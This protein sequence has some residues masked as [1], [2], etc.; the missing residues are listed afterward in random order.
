MFV[1]WSADILV[2]SQISFPSQTSSPQNPWA[3]VG[4]IITSPKAAV[5]LLWNVLVGFVF[6]AMGFKSWL[7]EDLAGVNSCD[8]AKNLKLL[9]G[10]CLTVNCLG[11][12]KISNNLSDF[13]L[14]FR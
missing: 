12:D 5:F 13:V 8:A 6:G 4:S 14:I 3:K 11:E 2:V 1:S 9:Q 10:L 7:L